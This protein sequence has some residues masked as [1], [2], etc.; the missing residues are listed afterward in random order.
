MRKAG[1]ESSDPTESSNSEDTAKP[2]DSIDSPDE[3]SEPEGIDQAEL[4]GDLPPCEVTAHRGEL[5]ADAEELPLGLEESALPADDWWADRTEA[6]KAAEGAPFPVV[7]I[8]GSAGGLEASRDL[9]SAL[10][11]DTGM[12]FIVVHHLSAAHDSLL[13]DI[14]ARATQMPVEFAADGVRLEPD[15]VYVAPPNARVALFHGTIN[16]L[17]PAVSNLVRTTIDDFFRSLAEDQQRMAIGVVLSGTGADGALGVRAIK[18]E[19]GITMAQEPTTAAYDG[20][21]RSAIQTGAVDV[22]LP[23][24]QI[25]REL[26]RLAGHPYLR[27]KPVGL[28]NGLR[29]DEERSLI[30]RVFARLRDAKG[31]DFSCYK[32]TTMKRRIARRIVVHKLDGLREYLEY[33]DAHPDE[34]D[35]LYQD[36]LI[37]V[38]G[39]FREPESYEALRQEVFPKLVEGRRSL[40]SIRIWVPGCST[41][42]EAY[43][44]AIT[45]F[46]YLETQPVKPQVQVFATDVS[47]TSIEKARTGIYPE[48]I[49]SEVGAERLSKYF[50][51]TDGGYQVSKAIRDACVFAKH[52]VTKDPP[53]SRLDL[54][55]C[56]NLLIYLGQAIQRRLIPVFHYALQPTGYLFLGS[57][58][59]IG[60][61]S[62]LFTIVNSRFKIYAKKQTV[63]RPPIDFGFR[64][65][66]PL[67]LS[68][69]PRGSAG[70]AGIGQM[71]NVQ[72]EADRIASG[73]F[74]PPGVLVDGDMNI[75]QFRGDTTPFLRHSPGRASLNLFEMASEGLRSVLRARLSGTDIKDGRAIRIDGV[76]VRQNGHEIETDLEIVPFTVGSEERHYLIFF[77]QPAPRTPLGTLTGGVSGLE[78]ENREVGQLLLEVGQLKEQLR[79]TVEEKDSSLEELR[80]ANEEIQSSNEEL[81]SIN[82]EL[83]TAKEELQ[84]TNEEL[85]TLNEELQNRNFELLSINDDLRNVFTS[86]NIPIII[87]GKDTCIRRYTPMAER[88]LS[89]IP[90]DIGRPIG[91]LKLKIDVPDLELLIQEVIKTLGVFEREVRDDAG[92]WYR[93]QLRPYRTV[94]DRIEGVVIAL[95]EIDEL[96]SASRALEDE[97]RELEA[98]KQYFQVILDAVN[99]AVIV[100]RDDTIVALNPAVERLLGVST[101]GMIGR[102][103]TAMTSGVFAQT[104]FASLLGKSAEA[105]WQSDTKIE[106]SVAG[107]TKELVARVRRI[108]GDD[109]SIVIALALHPVS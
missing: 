71:V 22:V 4:E 68:A 109:G 19:D 5:S 84:S 65:Y 105:D 32:P 108:E 1:K 42:E 26:A 48:N 85:T 82:E 43:S 29:K 63:A 20:M 34:T 80:A 88:V 93:L 7:G 100:V 15:H 35:A 56:R 107:V 21:P 33:L 103:V 13:V 92:H 39:F 102:P 31:V 74:I 78:G 51:S 101:A 49:S 25:A 59:S 28:G 66:S 64:Q 91:D 6:E 40:D 37:N 8:G 67:A 69:T 83:E 55:S 41:G 9:L 79:M 98:S 97:R 30:E 47:E 18:A 62:N 50:R 81:Q 60:E 75:L 72:K 95:V 96:K 16:L 57:S 24:K 94:E 17:P 2:A 12:A 58:E 104:P 53:F 36:L 61:Y 46:E 90:T 23:P 27:E 54:I 3:E 14:L 52:D 11:T 89:L 73:R 99:D 44:L 38:T 70:P 76:R 87:L 45:L 10:P 77:K 106:V 86:V